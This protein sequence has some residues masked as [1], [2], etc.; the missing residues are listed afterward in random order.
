M[1]SPSNI[2]CYEINKEIFGAFCVFVKTIF[3]N[4]VLFKFKHVVYPFWLKNQGQQGQNVIKDYNVYV[5]FICWLIKY[6]NYILNIF[7][8]FLKYS[9]LGFDIETKI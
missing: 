2:S 3:C 7:F 6:Q 9:F 8:Q 5:A 1:W 4:N